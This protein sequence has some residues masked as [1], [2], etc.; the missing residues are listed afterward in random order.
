MTT[1]RGTTSRTMWRGVLVLMGCFAA[2]CAIFAFV[3]TALEAWQ[4][5]AQAQWPEVT[6]RIQKCVVSVSRKSGQRASE[7]QGGYYYIAC[8]ITYLIGAEEIG[9]RVLSS[10]APAPNVLKRN[11]PWAIVDELQSWVEEH[12]QGTLIAVHYD[13]TNHRKAALV[14]TDMPMG[15]PR[16]PSNMKLLGFFAAASAVLLSIAR[17][18]RPSSEATQDSDQ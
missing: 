5:H 12:P 6:A 14:R 3:V 2:L 10:S 7:N 1:K 4:E 11:N 8:R 15:G 13:P 18:T 17:I 9:T 16:T